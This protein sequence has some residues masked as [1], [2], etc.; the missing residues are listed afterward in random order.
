M[1]RVKVRNVT[2]YN[3]GLRGQ[4]GM[5]YNIEAGSFRMIPSEDVEYNMVSAPSLFGNPASLVVESEELNASVGIDPSEIEIVDA[6]TAE[7][8]LK[9][10]TAKLRAWLTENNVAHVRQAVLDAAKNVDLPMSKIRVLE[11]FFPANNFAE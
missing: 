11:E 5:G 4:N 9:G 3:I 8:Y 2:K 6:A 1:S 10:S 7:K